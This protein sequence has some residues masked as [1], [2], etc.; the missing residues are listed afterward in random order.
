[1]ARRLND[2]AR[3][4]ASFDAR[5]RAFDRFYEPRTSLARLLYAPVA[6]R[7][8]ATLERCGDV[9]GISILDAGC[10]SGRYAVEL[11][12]R[13][14]HVTG[15]DIAPAMLEVARARAE[16]AGVADRCSFAQAGIEALEPDAGR[17]IVLAIGVLDY[18]A[19]P[20][21]I[22]RALAGLTGSLL[23]AS[24][25]RPLAWRLQARRLSAAARAG[26]PRVH[27]HTTTTIAAALGEL[28]FRTVACERGLAF[29]SRVRG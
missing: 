9:G 16:V 1:M 20:R 3:I 21:P 19:D 27:A 24:Y 26:A 7:L 12:R 23:V 18:V 2:P 22:L 4:A 8:E 5:A 29:A 28:G 14:A 6:E 11:A 25:P 10:G 13:G 17:E 15:I